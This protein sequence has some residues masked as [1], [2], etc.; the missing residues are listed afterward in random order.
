MIVRD[1]AHCLERCLNSI[2]GLVDE[3]NIVDTG[4]VD[5]SL[6]IARSFTERV[7]EFEWC[8]DFAAARNYSLAMATR[9]RLVV[10]D[11]DE[12][13]DE[14]CRP[15]FR[16]AVERL[17]QP[18]SCGDVLVVS[19]FEYGP[20]GAAEVRVARSWVPRVFT[21]PVR[22][23]GA[24]HEQPEGPERT[25]RLGLTFHHDGYSRRAVE[26][27]AGRNIAI[28]RA[29]LTDAPDNPYL[30]FQLGRELLIRGSQDGAIVEFSAAYAL[31]PPLAPYR[32]SVILALGTALNRT[33]RYAE[34]ATLF[35]AELSS[36]NDS[37]D[38]YFAVGTTLIN[39]APERPE[40]ALTRLLPVA[41]SSFERCLELGRLSPGQTEIAGTDSY[42]AARNLAIIYRLAYADLE[43]AAH[44]E[45]LEQ[46]LLASSSS[47]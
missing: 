21:R 44:Y 34:A 2:T 5:G 4:S 23:V 31:A 40:D 18:G 42:H 39:W 36:F 22:Y 33:A 28:L 35:E 11:A 25:I 8:G 9:D 24:I 32:L 45:A 37:A 10:L 41:V 17:C 12:W 46:A 43:S 7:Y 14:A 19:P 29:S 27:K 13:L 47:A 38:L 15:N 3:I 26:R 16:D 6:E 1:E 20:D 30:R